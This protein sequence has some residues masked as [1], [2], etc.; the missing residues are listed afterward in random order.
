MFASVLYVIV[1]NLT[2]STLSLSCSQLH[3]FIV[4]SSELL[5]CDYFVLAMYLIRVRSR[6]YQVMRDRKLFSYYSCDLLKQQS[7]T[8]NLSTTLVMD[9]YLFCWQVLISCD[10]LIH[11]SFHH[12]LI[13]QYFSE[14]FNFFGMSNW[15]MYSM[16]RTDRLWYISFTNWWL[17]L[18]AWWL[19]VDDLVRSLHTL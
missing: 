6:N 8:A 13:L 5:Y 10:V 4:N 14:T 17:A 3:Y 1:S 12:L 9:Y 15:A 2:N 18:T 16:Y 7:H 19:R 11:W